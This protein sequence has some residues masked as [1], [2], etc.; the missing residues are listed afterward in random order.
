MS[1]VIRLR[2]LQA[3]RPQIPMAWYFDPAIF[4]LEKKHLFDAGS[5]YVGHELMV[6]NVGD[7]YTFPWA[8]HSRMLVHPRN[9]VC[10][11]PNANNTNIRRR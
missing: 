2:Q 3:A 4:A 1:D 9:T 6:P 7:Y 5:N 8:N 11:A 10:S